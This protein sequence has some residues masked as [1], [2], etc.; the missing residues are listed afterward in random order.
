MRPISR[1]KE[2]TVR[3]FH[4]FLLGPNI[5]EDRSRLLRG[6]IIDVL[7][8]YARREEVAQLLIDI[9]ERATHLASQ[10]SGEYHSA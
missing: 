9:L 5:T 1:T 4:Q 6:L 3:S 8:D 10:W 2:A 7:P